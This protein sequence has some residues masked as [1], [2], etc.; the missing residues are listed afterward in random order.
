MLLTSFIVRYLFVLVLRMQS[1]DLLATII[2]LKNKIFGNIFVFELL[3]VV[4]IL[5]TYVN[6]GRSHVNNIYNKLAFKKM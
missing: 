1:F 6:F 5:N 2:V 4:E 3:I